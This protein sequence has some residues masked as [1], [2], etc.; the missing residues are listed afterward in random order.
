MLGSSLFARSHSHSSS[1]AFWNPPL[2]RSLVTRSLPV[3]NSVHKTSRLH[4]LYAFWTSSKTSLWRCRLLHS[5]NF[6]YD[7][8]FWDG[9]AIAVRL[10]EFGHNTTTHRHVN[11]DHRRGRN[12]SQETHEHEQLSCR[13]QRSPTAI[14]YRFGKRARITMRP[15]T[16]CARSQST[17]S[18]Q[19][20]VT[21]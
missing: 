20:C 13:R 9:L 2:T 14:D 4:S 3:S 12:G 10:T 18:P 15:Q 7:V 21:F 6:I 11:Q 5:C 17:T 19:I 8:V 16:K 1:A